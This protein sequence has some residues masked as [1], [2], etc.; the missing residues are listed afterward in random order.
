MPLQP[1]LKNANAN[2]N[3]V[4]ANGSTPLH[5]AALNGHAAIVD[6]LLH[7][8][9]RPNAVDTGGDTPPQRARSNGHHDI[10]KRLREW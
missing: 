1:N 8:N 10:A 4:N 3:A 7:A 2:V 9:A 5:W 6:L